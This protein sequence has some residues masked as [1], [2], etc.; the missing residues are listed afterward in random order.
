MPESTNIEA[1]KHALDAAQRRAPDGSEY[2]L[3]RDLM[4][5]L[6]YVRWEN[7]ID[8]VRKAMLACDKGDVSS[9]HHFPDGESHFARQGRAT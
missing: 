8:V 5:I 3:A 1:Y 9:D 7:F 4:R 2:W 6:N